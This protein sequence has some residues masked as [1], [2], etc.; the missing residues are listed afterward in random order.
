MSCREARHRP[1]RPGLDTVEAVG[2]AAGRAVGGAAGGSCRAQRFR[3]IS[4]G[5]TGVRPRGA[6]FVRCAV[7]GRQV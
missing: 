5:G 4:R 7:L 6:L 3:R 1:L 2:P